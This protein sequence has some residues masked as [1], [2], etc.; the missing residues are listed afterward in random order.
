MPTVDDDEWR[1]RDY[2]F[3]RTGHAADAPSFRMIA[4]KRRHAGPD[5]ARHSQRGAGTVSL[6]AIENCVKVGEGRVEPNDL[7]RHEW[8]LERRA[9]RASSR[10]STSPCEIQ[11]AF[12]LSAA[13]I[14]RSISARNQASCAA[15]SWRDFMRAA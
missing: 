5:R 4:Q 13:S 2:Q 10:P 9:I 14:A 11:V 12:G 3:A 1:P 8:R 6:D 15:A 7:D